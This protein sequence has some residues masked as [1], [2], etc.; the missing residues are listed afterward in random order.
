MPLIKSASV[1]LKIFHYLDIMPN[2]FWMLYFKR[3]FLLTHTKNT[4]RY[5]S[6][7]RT[8]CLLFLSY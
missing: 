8:C 2:L 5:L 3:H 7:K 6:W 1:F 4:Q